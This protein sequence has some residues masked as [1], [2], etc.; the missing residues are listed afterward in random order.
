VAGGGADDT[1]RIWT[2]ADP[3]QPH[4][5]A[6]P[7]DGPTHYVFALAFS[8]DGSTLAAAGGD[9]SVWAWTL[10]RSTPPRLTAKLHAANPGGSTYAVAFSP[11]GA[12]LAAG[13]STAQVVLW[14]ASPQKAADAV[15]ASGGDRLTSAEWAQYVPGAPYHD[16]CF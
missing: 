3:R 4:L 1:V 12:T 15:C 16:T 11:D 9:G 8:P 6:G 7:L 14:N 2:I 5:A 10:G 13:G